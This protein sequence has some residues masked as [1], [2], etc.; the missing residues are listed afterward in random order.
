[1]KIN[2]FYS[3]DFT[4]KEIHL[5]IKFYLTALKLNM[6]CFIEVGIKEN[7]PTSKKGTFGRIDLIVKVNNRFIGIE[8]KK[9]ANNDYYSHKKQLLKYS[10]LDIPIVF[11]KEEKHIEPILRCLKRQSL[12][13]KIHSYDEQK[14]VLVM[15]LN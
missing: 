2:P 8:C 11:C 3:L 15:V 4:E 12:M 13:N 7:N 6:E 10:Q 5:Q 14:Q 9:S 1:M